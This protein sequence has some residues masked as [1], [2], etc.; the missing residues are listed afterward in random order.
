V[1]SQTMSDKISTM[2]SK[3]NAVGAPGN[4]GV[5]A[6]VGEDKG[7]I[8]YV[9]LAYAQQLSL[10]TAY[11]RTGDSPKAYYVPPT[12]AGAQAAAARAYVAGTA[13][14]PVN[15]G[16]VESGKFYQPVNQKGATSYPISGYTWVLMYAD[17][18]GANDPGL[19]KTQALVAWVAWCLSLSGGQ[20]SM[21]ALGYAPL[22]ASVAGAAT[23]QLHT[24][25]YGGATVWP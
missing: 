2:P 9:E 1:P 19:K 24:I 6:T 4:E 12:L 3:A 5:S 15:P 16:T 8:G 20:A 7:S 22:P 10:K 25:K 11:M 13:D 17:Y 18:K 21:R 23:A 14:D